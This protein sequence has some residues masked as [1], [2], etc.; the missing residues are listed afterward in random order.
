MLAH[1]LK[2]GK[3]ALRHL[4]E[5][6]LPNGHMASLCTEQPNEPTVCV[7]RMRVE[8]S[9][10]DE[11]CRLLRNHINSNERERGLVHQLVGH[12]AKVETIEI[13]RGHEQQ[14]CPVEVGA[15]EPTNHIGRIGEDVHVPMCKG[16]GHIGHRE[17]VQTLVLETSGV[18]IYNGLV[19]SIHGALVLWQ[20]IAGEATEGMQLHASH[21]LTPSMTLTDGIDG[22]LEF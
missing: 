2:V 5:E 11:I 10:K 3:M 8:V 19:G 15:L 14:D 4:L 6:G 13:A 7:G 22:C 17:G 1:E 18:E 16:T 9:A 12:L 21:H 20:K